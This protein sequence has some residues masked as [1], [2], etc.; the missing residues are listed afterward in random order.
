MNSK[1][2]ARLRP[3][4]QIEEIAVWEKSVMADLDLSEFDG[5]K[6]QGST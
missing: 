6:P 5:Q 2:S 1:L 4:T 3:Q